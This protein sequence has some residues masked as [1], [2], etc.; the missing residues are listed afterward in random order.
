MKNRRKKFR[1][2][3]RSLYSALIVLLFVSIG[4]GYSIINSSV[5]LNGRLGVAKTTWSVYFDNP[6]VIEGSELQTS[7]YVLNSDKTNITLNLKFLN[8][9]EEYKLYVEVV[10]DGTIDA[11]VGNLNISGLTTEQQKL[12]DYEVTYSDGTPILQNDILESKTRDELLIT[13]SYGLRLSYKEYPLNDSNMNVYVNLN[14]IQNKKNISLKHNDLYT[15]MQRKASL[16][17]TSSKYVTSSTGINFL[18]NSSK[19]NGEGVYTR[20]G[21]QNSTYPIYYY[22]GNVKDNNVKFANLC[23]KI[24]RTTDRGGI[25]LIYNGTP[26]NGICDNT[27]ENSQLDKVAFNTYTK[28]SIADVGYKYGARYEVDNNAMV[29]SLSWAYGNDVTYSNGTYT[30]VNTITTPLG[31]NSGH[32]SVDN[33]HHYTCL[34]TKTSCS[35]VYYI[36][37]AGL[38]TAAYFLPLSNGKLL[39]GVLGEMTYNTTNANNSNIK[40]YIENW[41]RNNLTSYTS[42][43]EDTVWCNDRSI[44]DYNGWNK[45]AKSNYDSFKFGAANRLE[46]IYSPSTTCP[47]AKDKFT[48]STSYGNGLLTYP[49]GLITA[50]E[51]MMASAGTDSYLYTGTPYWTMSPSYFAQDGGHNYFFDGLGI[52]SALRTVN[53]TVVGVRPSITL[54]Y[55]LEIV[56]GSGSADDPYIIN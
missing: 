19:T 32:N 16:D 10:N 39:D 17:S 45:D 43:L 8:P 31:W 3:K 36:Y 41:Y 33:G 23:W 14:Y 49:V 11:M 21:T 51:A 56:D 24:V 15:V 9:G 28:G 7:S 13:V 25:K 26:N 4:L 37:Y 18:Q 29:G 42:K 1:R 30:L 50:D 22:R 52:I 46:V 38:T 40:Q 48:V 27:G 12:I 55:G 35:T 2:R 54:K 6:R 53:S 20:S 34:S 47:N 5:M 44:Y